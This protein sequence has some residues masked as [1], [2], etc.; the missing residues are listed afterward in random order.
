MIQTMKRFPASHAEAA[1]RTIAPP[2]LFRWALAVFGI[3][4]LVAPVTPTVPV[5]TTAVV[6]WMVVLAFAMF[7]AMIGSPSRLSVV[8]D[9]F[10]VIRFRARSTARRCIAIGAFGV[11]LAVFDRFVVRGAPLTLNFVEVREVV[12]DAGS[13]PVGVVAAAT[14]AF[15]SFGLISAWLT[16][17]LGEPLRR[18]EEVCAA[19]ALLGY[20]VL[21]TYMGS[22]SLL[23]VCVLQHLIAGV[24]LQK[25][26]RGRARA[27]VVLGVIGAL[28][29]LIGVSVWIFLERLNEM[30]L[31]PIDSIQLSAYAY[32]LQP[33]QRLISALQ[34]SPQLGDL[35]AVVYSLLLYVYHGF[36]EF[37]LLFDSYRSPHLLGAQFLWVPLKLLGVITG[38]SLETD[39]DTLIGVRPYIYTTLVGPMFM[40]FG[41]LAP[42][43]ALF[44]FIC[45]AYPFRRLVAGDW[46]W[47]PAA[48]QVAVII[49]IAPVVSLF[50]SASGAFPL[51]AAIT[52]PFLAR[53]GRFPDHQCRR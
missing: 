5:G 40:D 6:Y 44:L 17:A 9:C 22:R 35:G 38:E 42:L 39:L 12:T 50:D 52:L 13:G 47:L 26:K 51:L 25:L 2:R 48:L 8:D 23:L 27:G 10:R 3:G 30:G 20:I 14:S 41:W 1:L 53:R 4:L 43:F 37:C 24:F 34:G 45:L 36:Y 46:R 33:S 29:L 31:S 49:I 18:S 7:G 21:S 15:A 19:V 11:V 32:T 28:L 16:R